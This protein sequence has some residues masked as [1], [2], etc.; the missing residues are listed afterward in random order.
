MEHL[1]QIGMIVYLQLPYE[2]IKE[3]LGDLVKRGVALKENQ[4]LLDLY[5]ERVPLYE[6]YAD[7]IVECH[8]KSIREIVTEI[9]DMAKKKL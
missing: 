5:Q 4:T 7:V 6:K 1:H 8:N 3:R 9:A 2:D